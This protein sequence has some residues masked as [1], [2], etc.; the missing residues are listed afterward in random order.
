MLREQAVL[1]FE[2]THAREKHVQDKALRIAGAE[3]AEELFGIEI[4]HDLVAGVSEN[5]SYGCVVT[6]IVGD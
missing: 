4:D 3:G 1:K 2:P 5:L 6:N